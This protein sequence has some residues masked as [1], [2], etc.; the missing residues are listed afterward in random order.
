MALAVFLMLLGRLWY[1]QVARGS[2]YTS[3]IRNTSQV[4]VRL[5]AVRGEIL[6]RNGVPLVQNRASNAIEFYFPDIVRDYRNRFG[7]IPMHTYQT[8]VAGM[9]TEKSEPDILRIVNET[10]IPRLV[11]LGVARDFN[12]NAMRNHFRNETEVPF[13]YAEDLDYESMARFAE[14]GVEI[15]GV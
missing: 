8:P 3:R 10:V 5:P 13:T 6:D 7:D 14:H 15:A 12:A 4:S 9:M 2:E 11:E 1:V